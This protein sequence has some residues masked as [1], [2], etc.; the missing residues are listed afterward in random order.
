MPRGQAGHG[1]ALSAPAGA[2]SLPLRWRA[3]AAATAFVVLPLLEVTSFARLER[4]LLALG[5]LLPATPVD[6]EA[7]GRWLDRLLSRCPWPWAWSCLRRATVL[8]HLL[9]AA[10][11]NVELVIG[12]RREGDGSLHAHAW[13]LED[14]VLALESPLSTERVPLY[15]EIARFPSATA[16][17][18]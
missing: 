9:R 6:G 11:R 17:A 16:R 13:L 18:A 3:R 1:G 2:P 10:G 14:G 4:A 8:F 15:A 5:R 7:A 12:V